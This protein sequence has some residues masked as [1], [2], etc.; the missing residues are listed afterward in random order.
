LIRQAG[1]NK[2]AATI[3]KIKNNPHLL[4]T[5]LGLPTNPENAS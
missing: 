5:I 3:R 2:I 1:H 4:Y